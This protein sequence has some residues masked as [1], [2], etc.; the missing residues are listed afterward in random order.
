MS[1]RITGLWPVA[2][3]LLG[4][5][6]GSNT[7]PEPERLYSASGGVIRD[8]EDQVLFLRGINVREDAKYIPEHIKPLT[9]VDV[10]L[11]RSKGFDSVRLLT[12]WEAL[13][14]A[15]GQVDQDYL[16]A[17]VAEVDKLAAEGLWVIVDMHQDLWGAPFGNGGAEW[18]C[19]EEIRAG[20]EAQS[21]WWL[22]YNSEQVRGCFD[23]F[24]ADGDGIQAAWLEAWTTV[25]RAVCHQ[26]KVIGFDLLN[27]P[28]PGSAIGDPAFDQ[29]VLLPFY[30]RAMDAIEAACPERLFFLEPSAGF[31]FG[32]A[33]PFQI[34][35]GQTHR[36]VV[37]P[38][39]YPSVVHEPGN[40]Y[41]WDRTDFANSF[42]VAMDD[43]LSGPSPV[44]IGEYGALTDNPGVDVY[45]EHV[46]DALYQH[47]AGSALWTFNKSDGGFAWL[48]AAG[49]P[50]AVF[51]SA[52]SVP[53]PVRLPA[54]PDV[55][56]PDFE[57]GTLVIGVRC[58]EDKLLEMLLPSTGAWQAD[59]QPGGSMELAGQEDNL[60]KL[61]CR[62]TEQVEVTIGK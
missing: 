22:N 13:S 53:V 7:P 34:P 52:W 62:S 5:A 8:A 47:F 39:Y 28:W 59:I 12:H 4:V 40:T 51:A 2:L 9:F 27:E 38:H 14:P 26:E 49:R 11:I 42:E 19:P 60:L 20:Y 57:T 45:F 17:Y 56:A 36:V 44:W 35:A 31:T 30:E 46:T 25:A 55:L 3:A 1:T 29:D 43:H 6:C 37:A 24:W 21:P 18:T 16:D 58:E 10:D 23:R 48:D 50:K 61:R 54:R 33:D 41:T 15:Q 32:I